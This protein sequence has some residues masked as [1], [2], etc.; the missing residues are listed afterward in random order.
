MVNQ[1]EAMKARSEADT[2]LAPG[3][4]P[5]VPPHLIVAAASRQRSNAGKG[6]NQ[7]QHTVRQTFCGDP[8]VF[9]KAKMEGRERSEFA[10]VVR[11]DW[12]WINKFFLSL[13][14]RS[15]S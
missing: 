13:L 14:R 6:T 8:K 4:I 12:D 2:K 1:L 9:S 15:S 11:Y 5:L 3:L 7:M 10:V